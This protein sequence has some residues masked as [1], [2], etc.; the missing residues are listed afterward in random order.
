MINGFNESTPECEGYST[1]CISEGRSSTKMRSILNDTGD[2]D[3]VGDG[4]AVGDVN[5]LH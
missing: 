4:G 1:N 5:I 2:V 3:D